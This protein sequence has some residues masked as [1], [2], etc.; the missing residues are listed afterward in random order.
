M[1]N[2]YTAEELEINE[3][4][5]EQLTKM[6]NSIADMAEP[7]MAMEEY[8]IFSNEILNEF[9][10]K[11]LAKIGDIKEKGNLSDLVDEEGD[12]SIKIKPHDIR[13]RGILE[14]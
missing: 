12:I 6:E 2:K 8:Y 4:D 10:A 9:F 1:V 13:Y 14:G 3:F 5:K 11:L 7:T